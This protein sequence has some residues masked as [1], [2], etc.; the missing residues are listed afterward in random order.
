MVHGDDCG[1]KYTYKNNSSEYNSLVSVS[2][3]ID[4]NGTVYDALKVAL[5]R[6]GVEFEEENGYI[7]RIGEYSEFGHGNFSG[8]MFTVDGKHKNT[9][10]RETKLKKDSTVVWYYTDNYTKEYGSKEEKEETS[11]DDS[12]TNF[13]LDGKNKDITYKAVTSKGKTFADIVNCEGKAEIEALAQRDIINGKT[14]EN[15]DPYATMTRA[16]FA[17]IVVNALGLGQ[18]DGI[19]FEDVKDDEWYAPYIKTAYHYGIVKGVSQNQFDP[20]GTI[21][22]E[23]AAAMIE[24]A[25]KLAGI[26]TDMDETASKEILDGFEDFNSISAWAVSSMGYCVGDGILADNTNS[27]SPKKNVTRED[28]AVML[29]KMLGKAKLI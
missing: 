12:K 18:K 15:Y 11:K 20:Q 14:N 13:G 10:C 4:K 29:Y 25:A 16:E 7:S 9:G 2:V 3:T 26:K 22:L 24:R 28:I 8:W 17:T 5:E 27:V 19:E 23:E 6:N 1:N 21:T